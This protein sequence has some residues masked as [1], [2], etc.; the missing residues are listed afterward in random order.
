LAHAK[1]AKVKLKWLGI[2]RRPLTLEVRAG[3]SKKSWVRSA[4]F[5]RSRSS[6]SES[7]LIVCVS[8]E[9]A[10]VGEGL[11]EIIGT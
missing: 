11:N 4:K 2:Y 7:W 8:A 6:G 1:D 5:E 3:A 9:L 10:P